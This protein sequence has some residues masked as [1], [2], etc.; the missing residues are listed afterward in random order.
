MG[1]LDTAVLLKLLAGGVP[2]ALN[3]GDASHRGCPSK[4]LRFALSLA[5]AV[6]GAHICWK[7]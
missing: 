6:L 4:P 7:A 5:M 2:G 1:S 3:R